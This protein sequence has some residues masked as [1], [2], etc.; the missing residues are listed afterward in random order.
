MSKVPYEGRFYCGET[1]NFAV[2]HAV[3]LAKNFEI[4]YI[5]YAKHLLFPNQA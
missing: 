3:V 2:Y 5:D 1:V 4:C